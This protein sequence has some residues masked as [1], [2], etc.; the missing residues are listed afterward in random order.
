MPKC[1]PVHWTNGRYSPQIVESMHLALAETLKSFP[2]NTSVVL[3]GYSGGATLASLLAQW[4]QP[5]N[6][7]NIS[8][9]ISIAGNQDIDAWCDYHNVPRLAASMNPVKQPALP[10][11]IAQI[12]I[13]GANDK[14]VLP[15]H[16]IAYAERQPN[17]RVIWVEGGDHVCCWQRTLEE[18][19]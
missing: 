5:Q 9:I 4:D 8:K 19:L 6:K 12:F 13:V 14:V 7:L 3:I 11:H 17:T 10:K 15:E 18:V 1:E 2:H 16:S